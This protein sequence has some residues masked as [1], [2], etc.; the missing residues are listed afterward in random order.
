G[1]GGAAVAREARGVGAGVGRDGAPRGDLADAAVS[2]V[3]DVEVAGGIEGYANGYVELRGGRGT[4]VAREVR[5]AAAGVGRDR[6]PGGDLADAVVA[7]VGDVEVAGEIE[8]H[9]GGG[10]ELRS[11]RGAAVPGEGPRARA[12]VGRDGAAGGDLADAIAIRDVEV[13]GGIEGHAMG[14]VELRGGRGAAVAREATAATAGVGR[15][16]APWADLADAAVAA[17]R[18]VEVAGGIEG[19]VP[20]EVEL[21]GGRGAP[22][23]REAKVAAAGVGRDGAPGRDLADAVV[24]GVRD[25]QVAGGIESHAGGGQEPRGGRGA[26]VAREVPAS[27]GRDGDTGQGRRR[28]ERQRRRRRERSRVDRRR[29]CGRRIRRWTSGR[30]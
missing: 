6:A 7:V 9:A 13:A 11:G 4:A 14:G 8:S 1:G 27:V 21:R 23:A 30:S 22:V 2:L 20:G 12:G 5:A 25:I 29:R 19:N 16:G 28:G 26:A 3:R 10:A 17:V 18:D 15:D 24:G